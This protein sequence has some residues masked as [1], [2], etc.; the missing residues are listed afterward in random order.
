MGAFR[1]ELLQDMRSLVPLVLWLTISAVVSIA[2]PF[3]SYG[4]MGGLERALFWIPVVGFTSLIG[5]MIRALVYGTLGMKGRLQGALL[6]AVLNCLVLCAPLYL[7]FK[8]LFA[9]ADTGIVNPVE[10]VLLVCTISLGVCALRRVAEK[11]VETAFLP[12]SEAPRLLRRIETALQGE[13]WAI[14]VRDHYVDVLTSKGKASLLMRLSDA[15]DEVDPGSGAQV[16]RSH[17]VAWAAVRSVCRENGKVVLHLQSGQ[18]FPVSRN[19]RDKVDA[20]F[21]SVPCI[22]DAAA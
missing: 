7:L 20:R 21:P 4:A 10:I 17:W 18:Q 19:H 13:I 11:P 16:H 5:T 8:Q 22:K 15:M 6:V 14:S 3:G 12:Q 2:G 9:P 1:K